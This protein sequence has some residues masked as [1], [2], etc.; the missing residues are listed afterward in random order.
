M[1]WK[2]LSGYVT[3]FWLSTIMINAARGLLIKKYV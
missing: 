3:H 2:L 1:T